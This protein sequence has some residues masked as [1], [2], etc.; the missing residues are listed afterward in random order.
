MLLRYN[1]QTRLILTCDID[2]LDFQSQSSDGLD[3]PRTHK[4]KSQVQ[5][6]VGPKDGVEANERSN[7]RYRLL[8]LPANAVGKYLFAVSKGCTDDEQTGQ[9][10]DNS[11][12]LYTVVTVLQ[13]FR[14]LNC[15]GFSPYEC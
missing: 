6:S 13:L 2:Y 8:Y 7:G 3:P 12:Q 1:A 9:T 14:S 5:R 15:S 10:G 4:L 11:T